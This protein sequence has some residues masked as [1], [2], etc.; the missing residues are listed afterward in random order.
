MNLKRILFPTD[1][2]HANDAALKYASTLAAEA[3]AL[4]LIVHVDEPIEVGITMAEPGFL[5]PAACEAESERSARDQL[6]HVV[7]TTDA[8]FEHRFLRGAPA[9]EILRFAGRERVDLIVMGSHGRTGLSR[10]LM[11]SIAEEVMRR[12]PCPVLVVKQPVDDGEPADSTGAQVA[13]Q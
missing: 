10:L 3:K 8:Q 2:S 4:L 9:T 5:Y 11:G 12:A 7:P 6:S 13:Q 1:F